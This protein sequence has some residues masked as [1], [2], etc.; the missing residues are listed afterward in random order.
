MYIEIYVIN[1][2]HNAL[3]KNSSK[4]CTDIQVIKARLIKPRLVDLDVNH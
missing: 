1:W 3:E 2:S 4:G